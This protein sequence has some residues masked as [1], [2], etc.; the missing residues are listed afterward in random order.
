MALDSVSLGSK[1]QPPRTFKRSLAVGEV[2]TIDGPAVFVRCLEASGPFNI[3]F[4]LGSF[5]ESGV[6][7]GYRCIE[8][9]V[10]NRVVIQ[11]P[12][13]ATS[14]VSLTL[15]TGRMIVDDDRLNVIANR[16]SS[17]QPIIDPQ[18]KVTGWAPGTLAAGANAAFTGAPSGTNYRR[19]NIYVTNLDTNFNLQLVDST[20]FV[21]LEVFPLTSVTI[22]TSGYVQVL[23]PN[24]SAVA[25]RIGENWVQSFT[26]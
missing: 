15:V 23:N 12:D 7:L 2:L 13:T 20:G 1:F 11:N 10:F 8:G 26:S 25:C 16:N 22:E 4:D 18:S 17:Y 14:A 3:A 24:G 21:F 19:K 5:F 9:D 6:G